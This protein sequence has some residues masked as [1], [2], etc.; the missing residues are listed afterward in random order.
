[1]NVVSIHLWHHVFVVLTIYV[2]RCL[3]SLQM[4]TNQL[5]NPCSWAAYWMTAMKLTFEGWSEMFK[6]EDLDTMHRESYRDLHRVLHSLDE[7]RVPSATYM[8]NL[9]NFSGLVDKVVN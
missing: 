5:N 7:C 4:P 1:M 2:E 3:T 6:V 8:E 9:C